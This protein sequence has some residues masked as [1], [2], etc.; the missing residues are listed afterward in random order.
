MTSGWR[1]ATRFIGRKYVPDSAGRDVLHVQMPNG[2]WRSAPPWMLLADEAK[3]VIGYPELYFYV[4]LR[5]PVVLDGF[6][7]NELTFYVLLDLLPGRD[8]IDWYALHQRQLIDIGFTDNGGIV[9]RPGVAGLS[10]AVY[11]TVSVCKQA[12][13]RQEF[14]TL[15]DLCRLLPVLDVEYTDLGHVELCELDREHLKDVVF[16]S[17]SRITPAG[18]IARAVGDSHGE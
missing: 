1:A 2:L 14:V 12:E 15:G 16:N 18:L 7:L 11:D 4:I 9:I 13:Y 10:W 6:E 8:E 17:P 5:E 3:S